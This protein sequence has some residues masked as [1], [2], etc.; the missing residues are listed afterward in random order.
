MKKVTVFAFLFLIMLSGQS[1][2]IASADDDTSQPAPEKQNL[3]LPAG[4]PLK[5]IM[6]ERLYSQRSREGDEII[7]AL[8][9][10][11][12][13]M[14]KLYLVKS[15]PVLGRVTKSKQAK[16]WGRPGS[17]DIEV[18]SIHP[19][20]SMPIPLSGESSDRGGSDKV[21]AIG[22]T[23]LLGVSVVGLLAGGV[24][25]GK[26]AKIEAGTSIAVFSAADSE[27]LDISSDEM[28]QMVD[29]WYTD[30]VITCFLNYS[31]DSNPTIGETISKLGYE[32]ERED[33]EVE[34]LDDRMYRVSVLVNNDQKA[35]F[36]LQPFEEPHIGKFITIKGENDIATKIINAAD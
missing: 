20:Y 32:Y 6:L 29:D 33:I 16:S 25:S 12:S 11:V 9:E 19:I 31:W 7:F 35:I 3:I 26:G 27:V 4:T 21:K 5:L 1:F 36:T 10:D 14:G 17:L 34:K 23:L 8:E 30:K 24:M 2:T 22:T 13:I 18:R 28:R 15:T